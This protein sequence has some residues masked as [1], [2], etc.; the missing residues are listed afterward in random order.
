MTQRPKGPENGTESPP[1]GHAAASPAGLWD[2]WITIWQ[3]ELAAMATDRE[4]Q[5]VFRRLVGL[6]ADGA[7]AAGAWLP[8]ATAGRTGPEPTPRPTAAA[9]APDARDLAIERL[10]RRVEELERRLVGL[11]PSVP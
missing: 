10:A 2:D 4:A 8:D 11:D 6:W 5:A 9:A 1:A 3:S 7:R